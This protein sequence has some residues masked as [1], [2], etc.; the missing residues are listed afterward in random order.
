MDSN[1]IRKMSRTERLQAMEALW[2]ALSH[3]NAEPASPEWHQAVLA[4]RQARI[5]EGSASYVSLDELKA[6][7]RQP[8]P[9]FQAS[10]PGRVFKQTLHALLF[11]MVS[12]LYFP[13][14]C[15]R[16]LRWFH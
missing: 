7:N 10:P 4:N 14:R 16:C 3:E 12:F 15:V 11:F 2:D 9:V 6:D 1:T 8:S 5:T 13:F